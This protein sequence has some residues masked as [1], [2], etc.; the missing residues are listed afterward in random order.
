MTESSKEMKLFSQV[1]RPYT[2]ESSVL[3]YENKK[4]K[5]RYLLWKGMTLYLFDKKGTKEPSK[6]VYELGKD[7]TMTIEADGK[8]KKNVIHFKGISDFLILADETLPAIEAAFKTYKSEIEA[9]KRRAEAEAARAKEPVVLSL[10]ELNEKLNAHVG[11]WTGAD[12]KVFLK[13]IGKVT[14]DKYLY[15]ILKRV[16]QDW[17]NQDFIDF[18]YKEFCEED[19]EDT[20]SFLAGKDK[21]D[22]E[23]TF[24]FGKDVKGAMRITDIFKTIYK[25]YNLVWSEIARCLLASLASWEL[26]SRDEVFQVIVFEMTKEF[27]VAEIVTFLHFYADFEEDSFVVTWSD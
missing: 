15:K 16:V 19:L 24:V 5:K 12:Y 10:E 13:D 22:E 23:V 3:I 20:G 4:W 9:E 18:F 25:N 11:K 1:V 21:D 2:L 26:T 27:D 6:E 7:A 8:E 17:S 14:S